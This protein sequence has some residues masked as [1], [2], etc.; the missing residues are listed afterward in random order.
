HC[1]GRHDG[2]RV[3]QEKKN[4]TSAPVVWREQCY[5]SRRDT[6]QTTQG[7]KTVTQQREQVAARGVVKTAATRDLPATARPADYLDY[8]KRQGGS[9]LEQA[10]ARQDAAVGSGGA[11]GA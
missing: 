5:Y 6:T 8:G 11:K 2:E 9:P 4:A 7:G 10:Q 1:F 3:W